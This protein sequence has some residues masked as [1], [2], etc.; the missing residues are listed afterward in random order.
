MRQLPEFRAGEVAEML[1]TSEASVNG[2][3]RRADNAAA[4]ARIPGT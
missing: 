3:L 1:D 4:P 2:L